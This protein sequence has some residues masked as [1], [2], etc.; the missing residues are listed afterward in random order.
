MCMPMTKGDASILLLFLIPLI[1]LSIS[2]LS[3]GAGVIRKWL[4][5][6]T[7]ASPNSSRIATPAGKDNKATAG[8]TGCG[9]DITAVGAT[10]YTSLT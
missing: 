5:N 2:I 1:M 3:P 6:V 10:C 9:T 7:S 4:I 8:A